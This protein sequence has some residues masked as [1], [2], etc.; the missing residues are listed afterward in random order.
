MNI[1]TSSLALPTGGSVGRLRVMALVAVGLGTSIQP[2]D[3]CIAGGSQIFTK[4][5]ARERHKKAIR[6]KLLF[7]LQP[8][9]KIRGAPGWM[10]LGPLVNAD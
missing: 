5:E 2:M 1:G 3:H 6:Q 8:C 10:P 9:A 7:P 4:R